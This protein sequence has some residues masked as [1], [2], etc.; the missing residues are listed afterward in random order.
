MARKCIRVKTYFNLQQ[1]AMSFLAHAGPAGHRFAGHDLLHL[2]LP[3][4]ST[5]EQMMRV[6]KEIN[7]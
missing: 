7:A 4:K 6:I 2:V 5:V 3:G 1:C